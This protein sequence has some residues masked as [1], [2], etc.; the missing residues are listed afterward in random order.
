V[1][2]NQLEHSIDLHQDWHTN[3]TARREA[4]ALESTHVDRRDGFMDLV[5][6]FRFSSNETVSVTWRLGAGADTLAVETLVNKQRIST[7]HGY[8]LPLP[9]AI[10]GKWTSHYETAGAVVEMDKEQLP[11]SSRH[12]IPIQRFIRLQGE[13]AGM[14][15]ASP[16]TALFQVGGFTFGRH[17]RG[18][19]N[20]EA[21]VL[22]AWLNNNYWDTNFEVT[23]SGPIRTRLHLCAHAPEPVS[24]SV[25]RVLTHVSEPQ[26]HFLMSSGRADARLLSIDANGL[27]LTGTERN[28]NSVSLFFLNPDNAD[29]ELSLGSAELQI[30]SATSIALDGQSLEACPVLAGSVSVSVAPRDWIG[31]RLE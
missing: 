31:L 3:W 8:Y 26:V 11:G 9:L 1:I 6:V 15:V 17:D 28:G 21:P 18:A 12:F 10:K 25:N 14:S 27:V 30:R 7:P 2:F 24:D 16:D 5:Q 23:Q 13:D 19:V 22:L 29:C 4:G 20:R